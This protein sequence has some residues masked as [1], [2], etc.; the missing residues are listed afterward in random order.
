MAGNRVVARYRDGRLVK[1]ST[2]DF[3]PTRELFHVQTES[4]EILE[5]RHPEL[6]AIFFVRD[7]AGNPAHSESNQFDPARPAPGRKIRVVFADGEVLVGTTQGYQPT[8]PGFFMTPAD[9]T[10]NTERCF[11]IA[12]S[13]REVQLL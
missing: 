10:S 5:V 2:A 12:A 9:P 6:K 1:G 11:V 3:L 7:L 13:A 8:R 4:G